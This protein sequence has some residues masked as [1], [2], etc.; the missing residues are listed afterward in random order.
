MTTTMTTDTAALRRDALR[1]LS[2]Y[3]RLA[4]QEYAALNAAAAG[5]SAGFERVCAEISKEQQQAPLPEGSP[6]FTLGTSKK[7]VV[8]IVAIVASDHRIAQLLLADE[9]EAVL[10]DLKPAERVAALLTLMDQVPQR[11]AAFQRQLSAVLVCNPGLLDPRVLIGLPSRQGLAVGSGREIVYL[12]VAHAI[13]AS[14]YASLPRPS[15]GIPLQD[16]ARFAATPTVLRGLTSASP[17]S[18]L[19][20]F[21]WQALGA[22]DLAVDLTPTVASASARAPFFFSVLELAQAFEQLKGKPF[23]ADDKHG[24]LLSVQNGTFMGRVADCFWGLAVA[25]AGAAVPENCPVTSVLQPGDRETF[26]R[27][28]RQPWLLQASERGGPL[29]MHSY[30]RRRVDTGI[31]STFFGRPEETVLGLDSFGR[32][33]L[34]MNPPLAAIPGLVRSAAQLLADA[35]LSADAREAAQH[36]AD[37]AIG[38]AR[39]AASAV[40]IVHPDQAPHVGAFVNELLDLGAVPMIDESRVRWAQ[41]AGRWNPLRNPSNPQEAQQHSLWAAVVASCTHERSMQ[42]VINRVRGETAAANDLDTHPQSRSR[43]RGAL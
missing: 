40:P 37:M 7:P 12:P 23:L 22:L 4:D 28:A 1:L 17:R 16:L 29:A 11:R 9:L 32:R 15:H 31:D 35:G 42:L 2:V 36:L 30:F 26:V 10:D 41:E 3:V 25:G 33:H 24:V 20:S 34:G 43:R 18:P 6:R 21:Q 27:L 39:A 8:A 19:V 13:A 38:A 5:S 14:R